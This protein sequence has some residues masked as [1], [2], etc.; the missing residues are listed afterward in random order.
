M[1]VQ[2][3]ARSVFKKIF[4]IFNGLNFIKCY[5]TV[6]NVRSMP[7]SKKKKNLTAEIGYGGN[8]V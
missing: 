5:L 2:W 1:S 8:K 7:A 3:M 6:P 4:S